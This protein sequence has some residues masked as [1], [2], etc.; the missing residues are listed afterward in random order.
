MKK[1]QQDQ[2]FQI[3]LEGEDITWQTMLY[4]L[5]KSE[6]MDPWDIDISLLANKFLAMLK[7]MKEMN[8]RIS[9][10]VLL[11]TAIM[12]KL[13]T[14]KLM[15][16]DLVELDRLIAGTEDVSEEE[17][18]E[19]LEGIEHTGGAIN[20]EDYRLIPRVP[21]Q[22]KRKVSIYDLVNAL[23]KALEVKK[24]RVE[25]SIPE[26]KME[27][28]EKKT[29]VARLFKDVYIKIKNYFL[30]N[31]GQRLTFNQLIPSPSKEDKVLTFIPLLHLAN[32]RR[33]ELE[34]EEHF[35]EIEILLR[36]KKEVA[37]EL[38]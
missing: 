35:G 32:Q 4:D 37:K 36:T 22:R 24:R 18:Y 12:L 27:V 25:R 1:E 6:Q 31:R 5:V 11:A 20:K 28:P 8:F 17:F 10:N 29:E 34:Q 33:V 3:I 13:K 30:T 38:G 19:E 14:N 21:Q 26:L 23:E 7:K 16:T 9:G 15:D 2:I